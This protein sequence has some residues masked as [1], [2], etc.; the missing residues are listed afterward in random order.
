MTVLLPLLLLAAQA[1]EVHPAGPTVPENLLRI[2]LRFARPQRLPFDVGRLALLDERGRPLDRALLDLALPSADG[3]RIT[4]LMDP[5]RVKSGVG[6]NLDAGRALHAGEAVRLRL[7]GDAVVKQ[8]TVG[9]ALS[10]PLQPAG[11]RLSAPRAGS[12]DALRV[13]LGEPISSSGESLIAVVDAAGRRVSGAI[14]LADGD[15]VW[16]FTPARPWRVGG[17]ALVT[18]P[19]LEDPAGNRSCAAFEQVHA[20]ALECEAGATLPFEPAA[21]PGGRG[22]RHP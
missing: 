19:A 21:L 8:W 4:V 10:Q 17:H 7:D 11:W 13:E 3:R 18:H 15:T 6:P 16:R 2:E 12:R 14:A 5:G 1:V 20:S 22:R 9:A